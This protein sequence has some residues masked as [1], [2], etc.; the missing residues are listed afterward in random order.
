[1][2]L[3]NDREAKRSAGDVAYSTPKANT[4]IYGGAL[5][6]RL[7]ADGKVQPGGDTASTT[8]AGVSVARALSGASVVTTYRKGEFEFTYGAGSATIALIGSEVCVNGEDT[9]DLAAV[10][11]NDVKCGIIAA[12]PSSTKVRVVIDGYVK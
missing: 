11:T 10:T 8:F 12:V 7:T 9:V 5:C 4:V 6:N 2:A 3:T 1:M